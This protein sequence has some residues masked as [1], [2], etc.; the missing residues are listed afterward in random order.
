MTSPKTDDSAPDDKAKAPKRALGDVQRDV[1]NTR[2]EFAET[3]DALEQKLNPKVQAK[4]VRDGVKRRASADP[5]VL[6]AAAVGAAG[7]AALVTGVA[8]LAS[9]ARK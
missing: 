3:L 7:L 6:G 5:R 4:R 1:D 9:R 2:A 8:R